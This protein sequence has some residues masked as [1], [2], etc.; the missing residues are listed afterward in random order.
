MNDGM[1]GRAIAVL[2]ACALILSLVFG[3]IAEAL[4][5]LV[6][7][8]RPTAESIFSGLMARHHRQPCRLHRRSRVRAAGR[9]DPDR[10]PADPAGRRRPGG[11]GDRRG[12]PVPAVG[13]VVPHRPAHPARVRA[14]VGDPRAPVR[15]SRAAP[16][17][18][19]PP[20][21]RPAHADRRRVAGRALPRDGRVRVH[22]RLRRPR[23]PTPVREGLPGADLR[24]RGLVRPADHHL[25][26]QRQPHRDHADAA[27][28]RERARL[29]PAGALRHPAPAAGQPDRRVRGPAVAMQRGNAIITGTALG[30]VH[31]ERGMGASIRGDPRP[32]AAR[33]RRRRTNPSRRCTT[34]A[35]APPRPGTRSTSSAPTGPPA[36][37][38]TS[39]RPSAGTRSSSPR[40]GSAC[41]APSHPSP[42]RRSATP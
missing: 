16:R 10:R 39:K 3:F 42:S 14:G 4:T 20:R 34:G 1:L 31:D 30:R 37:A 19:A 9:P 2:I 27:A 26:H 35:P 29:R 7:G 18:P 17:Q 24:D 40:S 32:A 33:R 15:E 6:C 12:A 22:R 25:D 11:V 28:A 8:A 13:P 21:H 38:T 36:G 5:Q 23:R 41:K